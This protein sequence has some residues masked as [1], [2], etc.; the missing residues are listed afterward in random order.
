MQLESAAFENG[1]RI[2][3]K[4]T[5]QDQNI[6]P[7]L[8]VSDIPEDAKTLVLIVDDP[9]APNGT[10]VHWVVYNIPRFNVIAENS[11]PG[12]EGKNGYG[13]TGYTGPCPPSGIHRYYF[14]CYALT[15]KLF[16]ENGATKQ[17][18]IDNMQNFILES[19]ELMGKYQQT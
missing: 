8:M 10:F 11:I 16:L 13:E 9:D 15:D 3:K 4:Y 6:N 19:A 5:C 17:D 18:V 12:N 2:P 7:P 14:K 1:G